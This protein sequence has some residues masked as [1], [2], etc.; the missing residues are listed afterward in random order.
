MIVR[1]SHTGTTYLFGLG[2]E[3]LMVDSRDVPTLLASGQFERL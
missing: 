2:S 3:G 1:G